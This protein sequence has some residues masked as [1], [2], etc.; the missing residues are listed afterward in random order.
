MHHIILKYRNILGIRRTIE[1]H[2]PTEWNE[3]TQKQLLGVLHLLSTLNDKYLFRIQVVKLLLNLNEYQY[4][5]MSTE[6]LIQLFEYFS[7]IEEEIHLTNCPL[8]CILKSYYGPP[9]ELAGFTGLEWILA[10]DAYLRYREGDEPA[11]DTLVA[12]LY[13]PAACN[14]KPG[15]VDPREEFNPDLVDTRA[16]FIAQMDHIEKIVILRF[17][18]SCRYEWEQTYNRVFSGSESN[19]ENYGWAEV[20]LAMAENGSLGKLDDVEKAPITTIF[21]KMQID[22]KNYEQFKLKNQLT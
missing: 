20:F 4:Y 3:L 2:C 12:V 15:T 6:Q 11:L 16:K 8:D 9:D 13:R 22:H 5:L 18:E 10:D 1:R 21:L 7:W 19:A 14:A 17:Y